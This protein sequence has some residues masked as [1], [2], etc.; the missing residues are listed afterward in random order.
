MI[1]KE[2]PRLGKVSPPLEVAYLSMHRLAA[3]S[4]DAETAHLQHLMQPGHGVLAAFLPVIPAC[5]LFPRL[6][7]TPT[8]LYLRQEN[9]HASQISGNP[10]LF[11]LR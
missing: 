4:R 8:T 6:R 3:A 10:A 5:F 2:A 9:R 1:E 11:H 7:P